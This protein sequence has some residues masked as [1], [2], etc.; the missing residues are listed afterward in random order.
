VFLD[1]GIISKL[2]LVPLPL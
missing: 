1:G 2:T